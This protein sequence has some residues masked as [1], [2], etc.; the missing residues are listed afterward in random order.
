MEERWKREII[1]LLRSTLGIKYLLIMHAIMFMQKE[2]QSMG[3][4]HT[5]YIL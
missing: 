5:K 3:H 4:T 1:N 2:E